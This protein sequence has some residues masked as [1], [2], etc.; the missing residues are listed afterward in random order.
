MIYTP[1]FS[2]YSP[3]QAPNFPPTPVYPSRKSDSSARVLNFSPAPAYAKLSTTPITR[4]NVKA[5]GVVWLLHFQEGYGY[6]NLLGVFAT[7]E[8]AIDNMRG[9]DMNGQRSEQIEILPALLNEGV[10]VDKGYSD[11]K[12]LEEIEWVVDDKE[13]QSTYIIEAVPVAK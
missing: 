9:R 1:K 5:P 7:K 12:V 3:S 4:K 8:A 10:H 6:P 2:P 11:Y 13:P